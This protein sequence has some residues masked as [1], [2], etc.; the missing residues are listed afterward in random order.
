[1]TSG[2]LVTFE[3]VAMYFTREEGAVLDPTQRALYRDVMQENYE[4]VTCWVRVTVPLGFRR[5]TA[6]LRFMPAP[7]CHLCSTCTVLPPLCP[8]PEFSF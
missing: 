4:N 7:Q 2:G 6:E 3:E 8:Q 5:G 1:M